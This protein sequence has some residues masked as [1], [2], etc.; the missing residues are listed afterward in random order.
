MVLDA[1]SSDE[2]VQVDQH[3]AIANFGDRHHVLG[4]GGAVAV[5]I[6]GVGLVTWRQGKFNPSEREGE[7][8]FIGSR[9][10]YYWLVQGMRYLMSLGNSRYNNK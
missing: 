8:S 6:V 9:R 2:V 4:G 1:K 3:F 5:G 10:H 7:K